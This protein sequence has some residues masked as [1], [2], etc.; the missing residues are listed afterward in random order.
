ML[1]RGLHEAVRFRVYG[2]I[3]ADLH[4]LSKHGKFILV[5]PIDAFLDPNVS[6]GTHI[7]CRNARQEPSSVPFLFLPG[8][9]SPAD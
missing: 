4:L 2:A 7:P 3:P 5:S 1:C 8:L 9:A 6:Q